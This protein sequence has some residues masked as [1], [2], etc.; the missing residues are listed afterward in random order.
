MSAV[1]ERVVRME[2]DNKQFEKN[3]KQ[4]IQSLDDLDKQLGLLDD[5]DAFETIEE[6]SKKVDFSKLCNGIGSVSNKFTV[7]EGIALGV[8]TRIGSK[9]ADLITQY[10]GALTFQQISA[11]FEKYQTKVDAVQTIMSATA[12]TWEQEAYS[13]YSWT[14][15]AISLGD[16]AGAT[17]KN[18]TQDVID[19]YKEY[20]DGSK[21]FEEIAKSSGMSASFLKEAFSTIDAG[22]GLGTQIDYVSAELERLNWYTDE[23]SYNFSDLVSTI[24]KFTSAGQGLDASVTAMQGIANWAAVSGQN[25]QTATRATYNLAQAMAK[26]S[27][28][29]TDWKSIEGANMAT[30]EF[31]QTALDTAVEM[32]KLKKETDKAGNSVYYYYEQTSKGVKKVKVTAENMGETLK[33]NWFTSDVLMS[34]LDKYGSYATELYNV[35]EE[36]GASATDIGIHMK[37][38][39][40]AL[41]EGEGSDAWEKWKSDLAELGLDE[42]T[43]EAEAYKEALLALSSSENDFGRKAFEAAQQCKTFKDVIDALKDAA[44]TT[45]M[46]IFEELFGNLETAKEFWGEVY[47]YLE[48]IFIEPVTYL[49]EILEGWNN[50]ELETGEVVSGSELFR[51]SILN[52]LDA[53][54]KLISPIKQ[55]FNIG[56]DTGIENSARALY[57][58]TVKLEAFTS[59]LIPSADMIKT[60]TNLLRG[61]RKV[62]GGVFAAIKPI[63]KLIG[64]I[65]KLLSS[66]AKTVFKVLST[67]TDVF[68]SDTGDVFET[69]ANIVTSAV[70]WIIDKIDKLI[71]W[72]DEVIDFEA[73]K[74]AFETVKDA[75]TKAW[76]S[77]K[78]V[79]DFEAIKSTFET[80]KKAL[81]KAWNAIKTAAEEAWK[82]IEPYV[83]T[84]D[85][86]SDAISA[87]WD[88]LK[89]MLP[90]WDQIVSG[91]KAGWE[92]L[93]KV[94]TTIWNYLKP[95]IDQLKESFIKVYKAVKDFIVGFVQADDKIGYIKENVLKL[96]DAFLEWKRN[97][98]F[99]RFVVTRF[100]EL[101]ETIGKIKE[102][103]TSKS[104]NNSLGQFFGI[105]YVISSLVALF[106]VLRNVSKI[107]TTISNISKTLKKFSSFLN[108]LALF[109]GLYLIITAITKLI[110]ALQTFASLAFTDIL[111]GLVSVALIFAMLVGFSAYIKKITSSMSPADIKSFRSVT[112]SLCVVLLAIAASLWVLSKS[113]GLTWEPLMLIGIMTAI[114]I[115]AYALSTYVGDVKI[116]TLLTLVVLAGV[117]LVAAI[118]IQKVGQLSESEFERAKNIILI[119]AGVAV[120]AMIVGSVLNKGS[121][122]MRN[123]A[124]AVGV[125]AAALLLIVISLNMLK[126]V[127]LDVGIAGTLIAI[128]AILVV[129]AAIPVYMGRIASSNG[130]SSKSLLK[131]AA[132]I[133]TMT[134]GIMVI[135]LALS[136]LAKTMAKTGVS[137][138]DML[139]L[140]VV[141]AVIMVALGLMAVFLAYATSIL[142]GSD[143]KVNTLKKT[144]KAVRSMVVSIVLIAALLVVMTKLNVTLENSEKALTLI[145]IIMGLLGF[146]AIVMAYASNL[147]GEGGIKS[148]PIIAM[149]LGVVALVFTLMI[150]AKFMKSNGDAIESALITMGAV[151]ALIALLFIA[152]G[153]ATE[154]AGAKGL[155]WAPILIVIVG[156]IAIMHMLIIMS[157]VD[158]GSLRQA[159]ISLAIVLGVL[160]VL[161]IVVGLMQKLS[162]NTANAIRA[163]VMIAVVVGALW[164]LVLALKN[165]EQNNISKGTMTQLVVL[166]AILAGLSLVFAIISKLTTSTGNVLRSAGMVVIAILAM[167]ALVHMLEQIQESQITNKTIFQLT[168]LAVI[169]AALTAI[170]SLIS[171][172][173]TNIVGVLG[174]IAIIVSVVGAMMLLV[175]A[176]KQITEADI[177]WETIGMLGAMAGGLLA[178]VA[179]IILL[180]SIATVGAVGILMVSVM[181]I[182]IATA[183][184]ILSA[185]AL[186]A[187]MALPKFAQGIQMVIDVVSGLDVAWSQIAKFAAILLVVAVLGTA[188]MI[189]IGAGALIMAAGI[190]VA[191][192][193]F[194]LIS[195]ILPQM[196]MGIVMLVTTLAS[197]SVIGWQAALAALKISVAFL[198]LMVGGIAL[199]IGLAVA[200]VGLG[201]VA[202]S[203]L[204]LATAIMIASLGVSAFVTSLA[205]LAQGIALVADIFNGGNLSA[206]VSDFATNVKSGTSEITDAVS[207]LK[208][209]VGG[210]NGESLLSSIFGGESGSFD[211]S[212]LKDSLTSS[213]TGENGLFGGDMSSILGGDLMNSLSGGFENLDMSSLTS[214]FGDSFSSNLD[215]TSMFSGSGLDTSLLSGIEG[216]DTSSAASTLTDSL[217]TDLT[218]QTNK[219]KVKSAGKT[220]GNEGSAGAN[221]TKTSWQTTGGNLVAGLVSGIKSKL[222]DAYNAGKEVAQEAED[223][224]K[225]EAGINS[226]SKVF[227]E[228]GGYMVEGLAL[229]VGNNASSAVSA[230]RDMALESI[231]TAT[232]IIADTIENDYANPVIRPTLDL[233]NVE[234]GA[235]G[236]SSMFSRQSV[237]VDGEIQN[238][239][240]NAA[241]GIVYNYTQ[242]NYSP[243]ALSR[244]DIYRQTK[245]L[246]SASQGVG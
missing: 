223:G 20:S 196:T 22:G 183:M 18:I 5:G 44:S 246:I 38:L 184:L 180:S 236:I 244:I 65:I 7:L 39:A 192:V 232:S 4:S 206:Q 144:A 231:G 71:S 29:Y 80:V 181:I 193:A 15:S 157:A 189:G 156:V 107:T 150:L 174:T 190:F 201:I 73:I 227:M 202:A 64:P 12:T 140:S 94:A 55:A 99:I 110:G 6:N 118:A 104:N 233:S 81:V 139:K 106:A 43:A 78:S 51:Q 239:L 234:A 25:A 79:I 186:V 96:V 16:K 68:S 187:S 204:V 243:K 112:V 136:L 82:V 90:S 214:S 105:A 49:K 54:N 42:N 178:I 86:I 46:K 215:F 115:A 145:V 169:L 171:N 85:Q 168:V 198:A 134:V 19:L 92:V 211:I 137:S 56:N 242:N 128:I 24:G 210:D 208:T 199:G 161:F 151:M 52:I 13:A 48:K 2:F 111:K 60:F 218:S 88:T 97:S 69:F 100:Q 135:A 230:V 146:L 200:G 219:S 74:S 149:V 26:G 127:K 59:K 142:S 50:I 222:I 34:T 41:E 228:I 72:I 194:S 238:G 177:S 125:M 179:V 164:A 114:V 154:R 123:I 21:T 3:I 117:L 11:G 84:F 131:M 119:L 8:L 203:A 67:I 207:D 175:Y 129:L 57:K 153:L 87:I 70:D 213:L 37:D 121:E 1:E 31:K 113:Q 225:D 162:D 141:I 120:A 126:T 102:Y 63:F 35:S 152:I 224:A 47:G 116:N 195:G 158:Q 148:G 17:Y 188:A 133:T 217:S 76:N 182:A 220:V 45:W 53:V 77:I 138:S 147:A 132:T 167:M 159:A 83:P 9:I 226:P 166:A 212:S 165:L 30:V 33:Y 36:Y 27:L 62:I 58:F 245:N 143:S 32:G 61:V 185:A 191:A 205:L 93:K 28:T 66:L 103:L 109:V 124:I 173:S 197:L 122:T 40:A 240:G 172:L 101:K 23:T 176:L 75:L 237:G 163:G 221:S 216:V 170:F 98:K 241:N 14:E 229:G 235:A 160:A 95:Y 89:E 209:E 10:S 155:Q 130:T 91:L 108:K